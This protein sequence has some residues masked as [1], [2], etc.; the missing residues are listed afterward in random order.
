MLTVFL[1]DLGHPTNT[2]QRDANVPE[3]LAKKGLE[4]TAE[5][6]EA[7]RKCEMARGCQ[8]KGWPC[9]VYKGRF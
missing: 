7:Q 3:V 2:L 5:E 9:H 4:S 6:I 8:V 1:R